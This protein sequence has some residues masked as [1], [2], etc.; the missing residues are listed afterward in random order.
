M[1]KSRK[2]N[3][4]LKKKPPYSRLSFLLRAVVGVLGAF[5]FFS[6]FVLAILIG[7][8][9]IGVGKNSSK[10]SQFDREVASE[11][12][13]SLDEVASQLREKSI[14]RERRPEWAWAEAGKLE[15]IFNAYE[16]TRPRQRDERVFLID[17]LARSLPKMKIDAGED[18]VLFSDLKK[19]LL[20]VLHEP[21][22]GPEPLAA[23]RGL[24]ALSHAA[25]KLIGEIEKAVLDFYLSDA[26]VGSKGAVLQAFGQMGSPLGLQ[27]VIQ[28]LSSTDRSLALSA[29][30]ALDSYSQTR[31][32]AESDAA[33]LKGCRKNASIL[34]LGAKILAKNR[35]QGVE[36]LLPLLLSESAGD[37]EIE[38]AAF[39]IGELGLEKE[40][41]LLMKR[42]Q[43][44]N[45][46][47][48]IHAG[49]AYRK[50]QA[51][52]ESSDQSER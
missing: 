9:V 31:L 15:K 45:Q 29:V 35:V 51:M 36:R 40:L 33:L 16:N 12:G 52:D 47:V 24:V 25:P 11:K 34:P 4:Q 13:Q 48:Q 17:V 10:T 49:E 2:K 6:G 3:R 30:Y 39:V 37:Q 38:A 8:L 7:G 46:F 19:F 22:T 14:Q 5:P 42:A 32:K 50:I 26:R 43:S 18:T 21:K 23:L 44:A 1:G 20:K 41:P 28:G 27:S